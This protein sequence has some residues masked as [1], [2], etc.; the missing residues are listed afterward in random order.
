MERVVFVGH[1]N[2]ADI[3]YPALFYDTLSDEAPYYVENA[4][5]AHMWGDAI[6][7]VTRDDEI[8]RVYLVEPY[9]DIDNAVKYLAEAL[10]NMEKVRYKYI[11]AM[12][13]DPTSERTY[14]N[15]LPSENDEL[16]EISA[17]AQGYAYVYGR[18]GVGWIEIAE[19]PHS[20]WSKC[21]DEIPKHVKL[22][23]LYKLAKELFEA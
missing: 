9:G 15:I 20:G 18:N 7:I 19:D 14:I 8:T 21:P 1:Y 6:V 22:E 3:E 17:Y 16:E 12:W 4:L 10:Y 5:D 11:S 2:E 23:V 13:Y